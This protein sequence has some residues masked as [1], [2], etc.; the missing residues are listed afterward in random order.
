[1]KSKIAF[2]L[3][4]TLSIFYAQEIQDKSAFKKCRKEFSKK[5]CLSDDDKDGQLFYLDLCPKE[6]GDL[7]NNGCP[8]LDTDGDQTFDKDDACPTVAGPTENNGCPWPDT[9]GDGVLDKDDAC[10]TTEG[11]A[12]NNGCSSQKLDCIQFYEDENNK[13]EEFRKNNVEIEHI[14]N[15]LSTNILQYFNEENKQSKVNRVFIKFLDYGPLCD[16]EPKNYVPKCTS[17]RSTD[18]YNFLVTRFWNKNALEKFVQKNNVTA[19]MNYPFKKYDSDFTNIFPKELHDYLEKKAR[20]NNAYI[21]PKGKT[22][23]ANKV[24]IKIDIAFINPHKLEIIYTPYSDGLKFVSKK[25]EYSKGK[26]NELKN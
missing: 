4:F 5:I 24:L 17:A 11:V 22:E 21:I 15:L 9:D 14:Y 1:M 7:E 18:E 25:L 19:V 8:W 23:K 12:E 3:I 2:I 10:P 13:F 6:S 20:N 26:W 16:Y